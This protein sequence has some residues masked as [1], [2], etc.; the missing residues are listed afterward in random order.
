MF[1]KLDF[2]NFTNF[3]VDFREKGKFLCIGRFWTRKSDFRKS[4]FRKFWS[5]GI[6]F[7]KKNLVVLIFTTKRFFQKKFSTPQNIRKLDFQRKNWCWQNRPM[8]QNS[9]FSLNSTKKFVKSRKSNF[10][11][12]WG[13]EIFFWQNFFVELMSSTEFFFR[14]KFR[15]LKIF[16]KLILKKSWFDYL[17]SKREVLGPQNDIVFENVEGSK[18]PENGSKNLKPGKTSKL[19]PI[20]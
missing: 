9:H 2:S 19:V 13:V 5:V 16:E 15:P 1:K 12:F 6:F 10:W 7:W 3:F 8:H 11:I 14:K 18:S 4:G 20:L 17:R